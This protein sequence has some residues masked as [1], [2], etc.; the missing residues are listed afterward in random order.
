MKTNLF[1]RG[2]AAADAMIRK[3]AGGARGIARGMRWSYVPPLMVYFA[4]GVSG[5]TGI[6]EAFFVKEKLGLSAAMLASLGF[7]AGLPWAM[8]MPLG[9]LVDRYWHRKALFVYLGAALMAA[10]LLIMVGLTGHAARMATHLP[11]DTWYIGSVLLAPVGFVLQDVVADAMTVEAV[12]ARREDGTAYPEAEQQQ[13]HVTMQTLGRIAIVGGGALVAGTGGW[14]ART[15]SYEAMYYISL[16]IPVISVLGVLAA[17]GMRCRRRPVGAL[18]VEASQSEVPA[19]NAHILIAGAAFVILSLLLGLG[20]VP[21]NEEIIFFGSLAVI[22]FP[23]RRLLADL[24]MNRRR[25]IVGIAIII[26]V[27]RAMPG[28]GA[29]SGWW[30]MERLGF[31]EAFMGT[32]RQVSSILAIAGML[33]LRG[34]MGRRPVPYLV[35][36]LSLY[37][38]VMTL[39][40]LGMFYGLHEW[41]EA[42]FGFGARTIALIDTMADSP[43]GQVAMIP[44]LAW[45]AKEAPRN[46]KAT[47]FAVMAAFT[48]L[49]L[50]ASQLGTKYLNKLFV[51]ERGRYDELGSLMIV[52]TILGLVLPALTVWALQP[53]RNGRWRQF[54]ERL[55]PLKAF[56]TRSGFTASDHARGQGAGRFESAAYTVGCEHFERPATPASSVRRG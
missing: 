8:K 9:H 41:T 32:L 48:N 28:A 38:T 6:I 19:L 55:Q 47:Y 25:A 21:F 27:F 16:A 34:W 51:V 53:G 24:D 46:Q 42:H 13:M 43:L 3:M 29:G 22:V 44:M 14:L 23:M 36:F 49:A 37:G 11:L 15:L 52:T 56:F 18:P 10:S 39:P 31:D 20:H 26:F 1:H 4:A 35:V 2:I 30:Q 5:F 40:F 17:A 12:P 54:S 33:A 50:S 7:W 45:I